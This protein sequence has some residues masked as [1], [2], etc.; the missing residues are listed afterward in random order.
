M[1]TTFEHIPVTCYSIVCR[2]VRRA[3]ESLRRAWESREIG[4][5]NTPDLSEALAILSATVTTIE[6]ATADNT[7]LRLCR[8]GL[9]GQPVPTPENE[10]LHNLS[11]D[12]AVLAAAVDRMIDSVEAAP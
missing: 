6:C 5:A 1:A 11:D 3:E 12:P 10:R 9:C 2:A 7:G 4:A 8:C